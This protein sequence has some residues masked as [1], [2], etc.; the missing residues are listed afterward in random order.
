MLTSET[1][2]ICN[3]QRDSV[4]TS[5]SLAMC[6]SSQRHFMEQSKGFLLMLQEKSRGI[7]VSELSEVLATLGK[8]ILSYSSY[9]DDARHNIQEKCMQQVE[10]C[11]EDLRVKQRKIWDMETELISSSVPLVEQ[12]GVAVE[13]IDEDTIDEQQKMGQMKMLQDL[14]K[15]ARELVCYSKYARARGRLL[16]ILLHDAANSS[17]KQSETFIQ[18]QSAKEVLRPK[19]DRS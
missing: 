8:N 7:N 2:L 12:N 19:Q 17:A 11:I 13:V 16:I 3:Y 6:C 9:S 14:L 15:N 5:L 10:S 18:L 1:I 4:K